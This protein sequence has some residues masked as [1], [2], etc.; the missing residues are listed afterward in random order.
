MCSCVSCDRWFEH[1]G[2]FPL[3]YYAGRMCPP[4][5]DACNWNL[6]TRFDKQLELGHLFSS[7]P[8]GRAPVL[9]LGGC[10]LETEC[11]IDRLRQQTSA[12]WSGSERTAA[13]AGG[14]LSGEGSVVAGRHQ[15]SGAFQRCEAGAASSEGGMHSLLRLKRSAF[16]V[17]KLK[18]GHLS[19][20]PKAPR[21][22]HTIDVFRQLR[23]SMA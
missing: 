6:H 8:F 15:E 20:S 18:E 10:V 3:E 5:D 1:Q 17:P 21:S 2:K 19:L 14:C 11:F 9:R 4:H 23:P 16:D 7:G 13:C 12:L 22:G